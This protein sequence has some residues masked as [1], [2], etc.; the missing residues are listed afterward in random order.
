MLEIVAGGDGNATCSQNFNDVLH[1]LHPN[2]RAVR[3][4]L[5]S[6]QLQLPLE[7]IVSRLQENIDFRKQERV[8]VKWIE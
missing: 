1:S 4:I 2:P 6:L 3:T 7:N 8:N 5:I